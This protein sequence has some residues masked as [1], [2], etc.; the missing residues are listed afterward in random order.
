MTLW[1]IRSDSHGEQ[2]QKFFEEVLSYVAWEGLK[3]DLASHGDRQA[4]I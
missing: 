3:L 4:L 1:L 2:D